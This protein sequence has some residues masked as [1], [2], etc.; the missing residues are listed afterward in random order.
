MKVGSKTQSTN[1]EN[2]ER[3]SIHEEWIGGTDDD[4]VFTAAEGYP[5]AIRIDGNGVLIFKDHS[6]SPVTLTYNVLQAELLP[7]IPSTLVKVGSTVTVQ[8]WW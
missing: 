1:L 4:R 6:A 3:G 8:I 5:R 7:F 2:L